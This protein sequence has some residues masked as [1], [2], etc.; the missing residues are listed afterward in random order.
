MLTSREMQIL[1]LTAQGKTS[2]Q[3]S[4]CL[5]VSQE[6]VRAHI[7]S[8]CRKLSASNKA[9]AVAVAMSHG[10]IEVAREEQTKRA[11]HGGNHEEF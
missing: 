3:I 4:I 1:R 2:P 10:L 7:K 8:I 5:K 6:T 9:H 11:A